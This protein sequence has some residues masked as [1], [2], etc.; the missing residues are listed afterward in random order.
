VENPLRLC[1]TC[2]RELPESAFAMRRASNDGLQGSCRE[3]NSRWAAANRPR[4]LASPTP[5]SEGE[6][7]CREC[8]TVKPLDAFQ[9]HSKTRDGRQ[10]YCRDC[11][12]RRYR[13]TRE[14]QGLIS[15]PVSLPP[16]FKFCRGC[17]ETKALVEF[18]ASARARDG[19]YF[20]CKACASAIARR[21]Y[22]KRTYGMAEADVQALAAAQ[23]GLCAICRVA[24][25]VHVDHDHATGTVRGMLCFPCNAAV[26]HLRDDPQVV[27]QAAVY[28]E[29]ARR[30]AD[31]TWLQE[32]L[33]ND[34]TSRL[35]RA[36]AAVLVA[37]QNAT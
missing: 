12:A 1:G 3:C 5:V 35:E 17:Q 7:W 10:T 26:G 19:R 4:K 34:Q 31:R 23:G 29:K 27:R 15:R 13:A 11:F 28:L 20:R 9:R 37:H 36:F 22:F 2:R 24:P 8:D 21:D 6:K 16:G 25:A 18:P 14:A 32:L 30:A 33:D